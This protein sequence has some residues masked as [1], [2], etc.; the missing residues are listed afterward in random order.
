[1]QNTKPILQNYKEFGEITSREIEKAR[2][3]FRLCG[4]QDEVIGDMFL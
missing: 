3:R 4:D 1:M 2:F